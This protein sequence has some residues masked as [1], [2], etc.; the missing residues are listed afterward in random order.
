MI[1]AATERG[2][3]MNVIRTRQS[4]FLKMFP[5]TDRTSDGVLAICPCMLDAQSRKDCDGN[6]RRCRSVYWL[7]EL[8]EETNAKE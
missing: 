7:K 2:K 6:C 8:K 1:F 3:I 5:D 4:E